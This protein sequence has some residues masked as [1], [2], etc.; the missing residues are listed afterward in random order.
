MGDPPELFSALFGLWL[1]YLARGELRTAHELAERLL[2]RAQSAHDP[3]LLTYA[4]MAV[5]NTS[6]WMGEFLPSREHGESAISLYERHRPLAFRY[7][8]DAGV[9]LLSYTALT[10]WHL[11][12]P[13]QALKRGNEALAL[14]QTL[15][16]PFSPL[17]LSIFSTL[18]VNF[19]AKYA[20]LKRLRRA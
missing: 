4:R 18:C 12:Y 9:V 3:T 1:V 20:K 11:G 16:H 2:R 8:V 10:L 17:L 19:A 13:D 5:A 15:S 6:Y 14:A 7:G